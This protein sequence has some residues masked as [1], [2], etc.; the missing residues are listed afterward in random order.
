ME[1]GLTVFSGFCRLAFLGVEMVLPGLTRQ[2]FA[3]FGDLKA[4]GIR[5]IGFH[6]H[7]ELYIL[8]IFRQVSSSSSLNDSGHA[9]GAFFR[10]VGDFVV[11]T[12]E[13]K[14]AFN[15]LLQKLFIKIFGP[16]GQKEVN[17]NTVAFR[18]P[19]T[20]FFG[21]QNEVVVAGTEFDLYGFH[22]RRM[23]PAGLFG[24]FIFFVEIAA[25]VGDLSYRRDSVRGDLNKVSSKLLGFLKSFLK[26]EDAEIFSLRSDNTKLSRS[27]L[28]VNAGL[29]QRLCSLIISTLPWVYN[30]YNGSS[31]RILIRLCS[32]HTFFR[33]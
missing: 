28:L 16:S 26:S 30:Y 23:G 32:M 17:L 5:L 25:E 8:L 10:G 3:R 6:T 18:E 33:G 13:F 19:L 15:T 29:L 24:L 12:H 11:H 20:S 31:S 21:L 22:L 1:F 2:K 4:L 7:G 14:H 27:Y 9:L